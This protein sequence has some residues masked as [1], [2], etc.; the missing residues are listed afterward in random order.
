MDGEPA[1]R[2]PQDQLAR[3]RRPAEPPLRCF[4]PA[5]ETAHF[6]QDRCQPLPRRL[7]R[8]ATTRS[9]VASPSGGRPQR[10]LPVVDTAPSNPQ[11]AVTRGD[12]L[13][14]SKSCRSLSPAANSA[15]VISGRP[16]ASRRCASHK[17]GDSACCGR[18]IAGALLISRPPSATTTSRRRCISAT[19]DAASPDMPRTRLPLA[20]TTTKSSPRRTRARW[21]APRRR[22][23]RLI[24]LS[25]PGVIMFAFCSMAIKISPAVEGASFFLQMRVSSQ[26]NRAN[27]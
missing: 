11:S 1:E 21:P 6:Q 18:R 10:R 7:E 20:V 24:A 15:S 14:S 19:N 8:A 9:A 2:Q 13:A 17:S 26:F 5:L 23:T 12:S 25:S 22:T 4:E 3:P 16:S 27:T